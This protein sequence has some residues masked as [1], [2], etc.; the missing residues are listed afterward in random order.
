MSPFGIRR[1]AGTHLPKLCRRIRPG[2]ARQA[3]RRGD[4]DHHPWTIPA[5]QALNAHPE[6]DYALVDVGDRLLVLARGTRRIRLQR[7]ACRAP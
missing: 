6:F 3:R 4:L 7:W 2:Q 1:D 5:N